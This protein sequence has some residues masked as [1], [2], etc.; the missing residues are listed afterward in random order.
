MSLRIDAK[1]FYLAKF[2]FPL[3]LNKINK[4]NGSGIIL[5]QYIKFQK[6]L[7]HDVHWEIGF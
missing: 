7:L 1:K 6:G 4:E 5:S 3:S 2:G